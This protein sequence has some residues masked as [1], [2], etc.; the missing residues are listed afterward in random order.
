MFCPN[1][2]EE[3]AECPIVDLVG[4]DRGWGTQYLDELSR[5]VFGG[6]CELG[7]QIEKTNQ[8]ALRGDQCCLNASL[9]NAFQHGR[10][11]QRLAGLDELTATRLRVEAKIA[12]DAGSL[13]KLASDDRGVVHVRDG[14]QDCIDQRER[15]V[16]T[17]RVEMGC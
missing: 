16:L 13:G 17:K 9:S 3:R 5:W 7:S 8:L 4:V 12:R 14:R 10:A 2:V 1:E 6:D 15:A 11:A